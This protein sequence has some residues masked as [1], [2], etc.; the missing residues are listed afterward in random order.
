VFPPDAFQSVLIGMAALLEG[1]G[2]RFALTGGL[3]SAFY[4]EPRYTQDA[5]IVVHR[6]E[7]LLV[8]DRLTDA[9]E[10]EGYLLDRDVIRRAVKNG[11]RFQL[12]HTRELLKLDFYP[13]ELVSGEL[14]RAVSAELF[15]GVTLPI[16]TARDLVGCKLIWISKGSHKSRRDIRQLMRR[17][18]PA[19]RTRTFALA[20]E[21]GQRALLE[22]VLSES[23]E[24]DLG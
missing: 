13:R 8:L 22:Q 3:V 17:F 10:A 14:E 21:L 7:T 15:P 6:D 18:D 24:I 11:R 23:D 4:G 16:I 5:D 2:V 1:H 19:E 12:F 20:E 9:F